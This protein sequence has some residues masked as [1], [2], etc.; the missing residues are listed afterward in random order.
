[1]TIEV[2]EDVIVYCMSEPIE[3]FKKEIQSYLE[4][5]RS[6]SFRKG[7]YVNN[8]A[9]LKVVGLANK[10]YQKVIVDLP[11]GYK[12]L[13]LGKRHRYDNF[14]LFINSFMLPSV[15]LELR[16]WLSAMG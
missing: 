15:Q 2:I 4:R 14:G 12:I 16:T 9:L 13:L 6:L 11:S 7:N 1:M 5:N 10:Y 3:K 8:L